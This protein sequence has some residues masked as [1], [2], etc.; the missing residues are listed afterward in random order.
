MLGAQGFQGLAQLRDQRQEVDTAMEDRNNGITHPTGFSS[1]S[2][3]CVIGK[4]AKG[5]ASARPRRKRETAGARSA[6]PFA[7]ERSTAFAR[8]GFPAQPGSWFPP[9]PVIGRGR[10]RPNRGLDRTAPGAVTMLFPAVLQDV[11]CGWAHLPPSITHM[12]RR[13]APSTTLVP[14]CVSA[15]QNTH[16]RGLDDTPHV[17]TCR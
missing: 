1:R 12:L 14:W 11:K 3:P 17:R 6:Q 7:D 2:M 10:D 4:A 5:G 16:V 15:V 8:L 9:A 13:C